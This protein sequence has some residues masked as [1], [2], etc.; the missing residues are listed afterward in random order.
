MTRIL[1]S[2]QNLVLMCLLV[3]IKTYQKVGIYLFG[4]RCRFFPSCSEYTALSLTKHGIVRGVFM[5]FK[6]IIKCQPFHAGGVD[7]P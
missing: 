3:S 7:F 5:A 6:R 1:Q 2:L 4:P